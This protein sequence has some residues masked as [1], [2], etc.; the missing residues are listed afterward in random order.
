MLCVV[1][2]RCTA[3][4][5]IDP[6]APLPQSV[7]SFTL[8]LCQTTACPS[9]AGPVTIK[10]EYTLPSATP[11]VRTAGYMSW[12]GADSPP[13]GTY[14]VDLLGKSDAGD[15]LFCFTADFSASPA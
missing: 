9:A 8:A 7:Y 10:Y 6:S 2:V 4:L 12:P 13:Q 14:T 1:Y 3:F 5:E 15:Q 11:P